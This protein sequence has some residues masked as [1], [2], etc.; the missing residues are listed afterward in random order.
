ML[1]SNLKEIEIPATVKEIG[2]SAFKNCKKLEK[3]KIQITDDM[4]ID[5]SAFDNTPVKDTIFDN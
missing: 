5:K 1:M 2:R 4:I 3:V